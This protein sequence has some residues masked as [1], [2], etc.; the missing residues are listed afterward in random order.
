[1]RRARHSLSVVSILLGT[2]AMGSVSAPTSAARS[3]NA[4]LHEPIL[5]NAAEDDAMH[6]AVE[7]GFGATSAGL[8]RTDALNPLESASG[9]EID[10]GGLPTGPFR[11]DR[12]TT[13]P[14]IARYEDP[15]VPSMGPFKRLLA[16]DAVR[17]DY[18]LAV[19]QPEL[20]PL[21]IGQAAAA[22]EQ[23]Y[24]GDLAVEL[25]GGDPIRVPSAGPGARVVRARLTVGSRD[26]RFRMLRDGA[27]NWFVEPNDAGARGRARLVMT[28]AVAEG[29]ADGAFRDDPWGSIPA[30]A[31]LPH[32]VQREAAE[33]LTVIGANGRMRPREAIGRLVQYFR[34]FADSSAPTPA[35]RSV[36]LDLALSKRGVCRHRAFAFV[37]TAQSLGLPT[38]MVANEAHAWVEVHDGTAWRRIDL[39]GAG[40]LENLAGL[41]LDRPLSE[42]PADPFGWPDGSRRGSDMIAQ[43][44]ARP[45]P[46]MMLPGPARGSTD[47]TSD[48]LASSLWTDA[49]HPVGARAW[50]PPTDANVAPGASEKES[51][52]F[53]TA[54]FSSDEG[55]PAIVDLRV[56]DVEIR[57]DFPL[58]VRGSVRAGDR[59]CP[60]AAVDIWLQNA[61]TGRQTRLGAA[62]TD[63]SGAFVAGIVVPQSLPAG[64]YDVVAHADRSGIC[65]DLSN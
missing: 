57:R 61:E 65:G 55:A 60:Y 48:P 46:G 37:V 62:A 39:G 23:T 54:P 47:A 3:P 35:R 40:D 16:F 49:P 2:V 31:P 33:V 4:I 30:V 38:R 51:V 41:T 53:S 29:A 19:R 6:A 28:L 63:Q 50:V 1:M 64:D 15:F 34:G 22:S 8:G 32:N 9:A 44:H 20:V 7:G 27:D 10:S 42:L 43:A 18:T 12:D 5:P 58:R 52:P 25:T 21:P 56:L 59:M 24:F 17:D 11:P 45:A 36:Y 13:R 14:T 26:V